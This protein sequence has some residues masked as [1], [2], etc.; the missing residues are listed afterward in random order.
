M[1][2]CSLAS[3]GLRA[4]EA[5]YRIN[6]GDLLAIFVWNEENLNQEVLVRPDGFINFPLAGEIDATGSTPGELENK[7]AE[8][9]GKYLKDKPTVTASVRQLNGNKIYV[10]GKVQRPGEYPINRP[11]DVMQA[12]AL[13][14]GL[15][16]YA[17]E[18]SIKVL[19]RDAAGKQTAIPFEYGEVKDGDDL[20]TNILLR[21]GDVVV[22]P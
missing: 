22:V 21:A 15:N 11:I 3:T 18:N 7:L 2:A 16:T 4:T 14:G 8:A 19:R 17:A 9:L 5:S 12:L 1:V 6:P 13:G 20:E 10:I